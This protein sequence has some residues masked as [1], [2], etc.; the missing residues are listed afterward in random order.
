[1]QKR[2]PG[3]KQLSQPNSLIEWRLRQAVVLLGKSYLMMM[4]LKNQKRHAEMMILSRGEI[5]FLT[6]LLNFKYEI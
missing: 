1:M 4:L 6:Q 3:V 2:W 5:I